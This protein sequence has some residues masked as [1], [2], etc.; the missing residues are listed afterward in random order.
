MTNQEPPLIPNQVEIVLPEDEIV[1]PDTKQSVAQIVIARN[2]AN[3]RKME[4]FGAVRRVGSQAASNLAPGDMILVNPT[5]ISKTRTADG[6]LVG[7]VDYSD[8]R[9]R[10]RDK[11]E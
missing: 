8:V 5:S 3:R 1:S 4:S 6:T 9:V 7:L 2:Y 11:D 10:V